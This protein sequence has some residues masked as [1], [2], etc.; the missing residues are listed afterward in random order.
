[1]PQLGVSH[2]SGKKGFAKA[3]RGQVELLGGQA[4]RFDQSDAAE[5][6]ADAE[7]WRPDEDDSWLEDDRSADEVFHGAH[8][9]PSNRGKVQ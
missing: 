3:E 6:E 8:G 7:S 9:T 1:M 5:D 4:V 2:A